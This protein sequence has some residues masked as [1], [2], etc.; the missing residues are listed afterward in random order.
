MCEKKS[1]ST[2]IMLK[3]HYYLLSAWIRSSEQLDI[4]TKGVNTHKQCAGLSPYLRQDLH[5]PC[6]APGCSMGHLLGTGRRK[7]MSS[8]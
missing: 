7:P 5:T 6:T 3:E 4:Y 2:A 1:H 8:V